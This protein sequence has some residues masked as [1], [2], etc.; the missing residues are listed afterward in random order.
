VLNRGENE[1]LAN[2]LVTRDPLENPFNYLYEAKRQ[3]D[4]GRCGPQISSFAFT[5]IGLRA[6]GGAAALRCG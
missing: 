1:A 5:E 2:D 6:C 4:Y 3:R